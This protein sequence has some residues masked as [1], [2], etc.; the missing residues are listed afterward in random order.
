MDRRSLCSWEYYLSGT[1]ADL[2]PPVPGTHL[3]PEVE[4][5]VGPFFILLQFVP[6]Q[7]LRL[8]F[9]V[10]QPAWSGEIAEQQL[11]SGR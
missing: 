11:F 9:M 7:A 8:N 2:L 10:V 5:Q 1:Q 6:P 3:Q 4:L